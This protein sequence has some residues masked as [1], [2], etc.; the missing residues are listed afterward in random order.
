MSEIPIV[1]LFVGLLFGII[2]IARFLKFVA[3]F[4]KKASKQLSKTIPLEKKKY[5]EMMTK[6]KS[7]E[8]SL[9][10]NK[11]RQLELGLFTVLW[12]A[13]IIGFPMLSGDYIFGFYGLY[14]FLFIL[15]AFPILAIGHIAF[16][17]N[18]IAR[19]IFKIS[20]PKEDSF[21][22]YYSSPI[23]N[24]AMAKQEGEQYFGDPKYS[25]EKFNIYFIMISTLIISGLMLVPLF[26]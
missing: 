11:Y 22:L 20:N 15:V 26:A 9:K 3:H 21:I 8:H 13:F 19:A 23:M 14:I 6:I 12:L 16:V 4:Y 7:K 25:I 5:Q 17:V 1:P 10:L 24:P 2:G 18:L